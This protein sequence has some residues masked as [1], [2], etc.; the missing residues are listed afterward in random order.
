MAA[1]PKTGKPYLSTFRANI[2]AVMVV[3]DVGPHDY[4]HRLL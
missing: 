4:T 2:Q 3:P 1:N